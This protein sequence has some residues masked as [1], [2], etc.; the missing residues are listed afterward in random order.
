VKKIRFLH[1][2]L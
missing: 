2:Q 1:N